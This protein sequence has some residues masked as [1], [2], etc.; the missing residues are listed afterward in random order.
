MNEGLTP[1]TYARRLNRCLEAGLTV[2]WKLKGG[3]DIWTPCEETEF[4]Y[5]DEPLEYDF[6]VLLP[7]E[8]IDNWTMPA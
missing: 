5:P 3:S 8:T 2:V 6:L 4:I 7:H 1:E